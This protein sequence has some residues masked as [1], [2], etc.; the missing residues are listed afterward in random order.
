M[1]GVG[2][3]ALAALAA[4]TLAGPARAADWLQNFMQPAPE[5]TTIGDPV[6]LGTGWYLRGDAGA[7]FDTLPNFGAKPTLSGWSVDLG[8]GYKINNWL[9]VDL[10]LDMRK[11]QNYATNSQTIN[12]RQIICPDGSAGGNNALQTLA[13]ATGG[14]TI[15][16]LNGSTIAY[17]AG[18]QI[19]YVWDPILGTCNQQSKIS[20]SSMAVLLNGYI[21]LG[22][23][24]GFTPYIGA[25]AGVARI[26][27]NASV[28][29]YDNQTGSLYAPT[30]AQWTETNGTPLTWVNANGQILTAGQSGG[31]YPPVDPNTGKLVSLST[32]PAWNLSRNA[33]RYNFAWSLMA[34]TAY[35]LTRNLK[36]D[37]GFRYLNL[38]SVQYLPGGPSSA[39]TAKEVHVGLRYQID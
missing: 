13:G 10:G 31:L 17:A 7:G 1:N 23:W 29:Y 21:D 11:P 3:L 27:T 33:T 8:A 28:N 4:A 20:L 35:N 22:T 24:S 16:E 15:T 36:L 14:T 9:R 30:A 38:G 2:R 25:G 37:V 6:E 5:E 12:G 34:G 32:P 26:A 39:I 18:Q 19:G